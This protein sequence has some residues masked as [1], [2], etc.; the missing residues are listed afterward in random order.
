MKL[1]T[2]PYHFENQLALTR[3]VNSNERRCC[4]ANRMAA[5]GYVSHGATST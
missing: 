4:T 2:A 1:A 5:A 3:R